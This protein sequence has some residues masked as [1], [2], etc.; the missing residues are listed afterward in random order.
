M[1]EAG[2][3]GTVSA[4][5]CFSG[6]PRCHAA[7]L[8]DRQG[9][10]RG[11]GSRRAPRC[12]HN[13]F[14]NYVWFWLHASACTGTRASGNYVIKISWVLAGAWRHMPCKSSALCRVAKTIC[15]REDGAWHS[16]GIVR[17][18]E[19][20]RRKDNSLQCQPGNLHAAIE[21]AS[22]ITKRE[23]IRTAVHYFPPATPLLPLEQAQRLLCWL[24]T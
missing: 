12:L 8:L 21:R 3:G 4:A 2:I 17:N 1:F 10:S 18:W 14:G 13:T 11:S 22:A 16:V 19:C 15:S 24:M 5:L 9:L 20:R 23:L 7:A 6:R